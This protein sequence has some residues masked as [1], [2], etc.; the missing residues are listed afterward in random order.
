MIVRQETDAATGQMD[1]GTGATSGQ[2]FVDGRVVHFEPL[3]LLLIGH[4][5][6]PG[7]RR[8]AGVVI[9]ASKAHLL[10]P[11]SDVTPTM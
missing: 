3:R 8:H 2:H 10:P 6:P 11:L 4:G 1:P 7:Q 9:T 5:R